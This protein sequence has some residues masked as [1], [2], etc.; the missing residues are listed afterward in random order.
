MQVWQATKATP[1]TLKA[2]TAQHCNSL[3]M[4][5]T[6][7]RAEGDLKLGMP[8]GAGKASQLLHKEGENIAGT[9]GKKINKQGQEI[10]WVSMKTMAP[11]RQTDRQLPQWT[12]PHG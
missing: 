10:G 8:K 5:T 7:G 3:S 4:K 11:E 9:W 2:P 1:M 12:T 6:G